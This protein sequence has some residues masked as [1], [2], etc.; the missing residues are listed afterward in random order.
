[1]ARP[2]RNRGLLPYIRDLVR[3]LILLWTRQSMGTDAVHSYAEIVKSMRYVGE[4]PPYRESPVLK[5]IP[6]STPSAVLF[7]LLNL[8][9][10]LR[11][12]SHKCFHSMIDKCLE[13][14]VLGELLVVTVIENNDFT[15]LNIMCPMS[16]S[17]RVGVG[18]YSTLVSM[19][20]LR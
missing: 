20:R 6:L 3:L 5:A 7:N 10:Q 17:G 16:A 19:K 2:S 13:I 4:R 15:P 1:M 14:K 18:T 11:C 12:V 8:V 9:T